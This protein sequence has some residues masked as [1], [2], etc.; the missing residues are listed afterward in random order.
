LLNDEQSMFELQGIVARK[1]DY[2]LDNHFDRTP[3]MGVR[4]TDLNDEQRTFLADLLRRGRGA[5]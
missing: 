1:A 3:G 5:H 2:D 4:F